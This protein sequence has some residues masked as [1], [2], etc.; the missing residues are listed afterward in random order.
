MRKIAINLETQKR[1]ASRSLPVN[2]FQIHFQVYGDDFLLLSESRK[3][4]I[5]LRG[6]PQLNYSENQFI[7]KHVQLY[8]KL[9]K[10]F[11]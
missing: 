2:L 3:V 10:R 7:F 6:S 1:N 11:S 9:T 8:I 4:N 5:L